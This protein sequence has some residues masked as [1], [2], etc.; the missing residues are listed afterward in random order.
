[1]HGRS[2]TTCFA[3]FFTIYKFVMTFINVRFSLGSFNFCRLWKKASFQ[4]LHRT[5]HNQP[6][7]NVVKY[8]Y[9][10]K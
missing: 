10:D 3:R 8:F 4:G 9:W 5:Q 2:N 7:F 1:M 6:I